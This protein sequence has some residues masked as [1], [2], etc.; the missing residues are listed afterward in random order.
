MAKIVAP[1]VTSGLSLPVS[2]ASKRS[3]S[4]CSDTPSVSISFSP[5]SGRCGA[6]SHRRL[7]FS[8]R[9]A[10]STTVS[11]S[12]SAARS[13]TVTRATRYAGSDAAA[14]SIA[15]ITIFTAAKGEPVLFQDLWD[16]KNV[17]SSTSYSRF[18]PANE[19]ELEK[20]F[21]SLLQMYSKREKN[22]FQ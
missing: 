6:I 17:S 5:N 15:P 16:Q 21:I 19:L 11:T 13:A 10:V 7:E 9:V 12:G 3:N 18:S 20:K 14:D 22:S 4:F 8:A 2:S 1:S